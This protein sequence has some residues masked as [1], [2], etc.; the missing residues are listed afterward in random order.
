MGDR[1]R[2]AGDR[3]RDGG[4]LVRD[5][6]LAGLRDRDFD[7]LF[8]GERFLEDFLSVSDLSP[9]ESCPFLTEEDLSLSFLDFLD[10]LRERFRSFFF[11]FLC[12]FSFGASRGSSLASS[13]CSTGSGTSS[14]STEALGDGE[15]MVISGFFGR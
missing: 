4:V 8:F 15:V 11:F 13:S 6:D 3:F 12:S 5:G 14:F 1:V 10:G 9:S 2:E 7:L